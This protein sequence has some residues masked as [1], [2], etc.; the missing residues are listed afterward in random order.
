[1]P[2]LIDDPTIISQYESEFLERKENEQPSG[3]PE[4]SEKENAPNGKPENKKNH[5]KKRKQDVARTEKASKRTKKN[6]VSKHEMLSKSYDPLRLAP[7]TLKITITLKIT[8]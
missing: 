6:K 2:N 4:E 7:S 5:A 3:Q 8:F 1:M